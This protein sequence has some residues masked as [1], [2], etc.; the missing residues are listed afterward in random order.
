MRLTEKKFMTM[1]R[2]VEFSVVSISE[3]LNFVLLHYQFQAS[4]GCDCFRI[5][6]RQ[7]HNSLGRGNLNDDFFLILYVSLS[8]FRHADNE[9]VEEMV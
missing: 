8:A 2:E 4:R 3:E 9:L 7:N 6:D 5:V 1:R